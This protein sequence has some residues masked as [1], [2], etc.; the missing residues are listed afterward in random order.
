MVVQW[1]SPSAG[2]YCSL[3]VSEKRDPFGTVLEWRGCTA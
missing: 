3:G 2:S 1:H